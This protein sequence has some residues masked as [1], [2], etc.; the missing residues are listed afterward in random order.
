MFLFVFLSCL[1]GY[2]ENEK[3]CP[4]CRVKNLQLVDAL[5]AQNESRAQHEMFHNLLDRC[6]E[7][8]SVVTE[9]YQLLFYYQLEILYFYT[10]ISFSMFVLSADILCTECSIKFLSLRKR[11]IL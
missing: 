3:D 5:Q 11:M 7:P 10:M 1:R 8:F 4:V 6:R 9:Y 2:S